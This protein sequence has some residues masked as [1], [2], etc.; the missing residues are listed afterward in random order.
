MTLK[1]GLL[2]VQGA[3]KT[4]TFYGLA[5]K[6]KAEGRIV[7]VVMETAREALARG[8]LANESNEMQE[9]SQLWM[10]GRQMQKEIEAHKTN[11]DFV[12]T[13]RTIY[14]TIAYSEM[15]LSLRQLGKISAIAQAYAHLRPYNILIY[16]PPLSSPPE[17]D[18]VRKAS[19]GFQKSAQRAMES[20]IKRLGLPVIVLES[21]TKFARL[22]EVLSIIYEIETSR[23][24]SIGI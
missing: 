21:K 4:T 1:I 17:I 13:D 15:F 20:M 19:V 2:G 16:F 3:G 11:S 8:L 24:V 22:D 9:A 10:L 14:D 12:I 5:H 6:L 7:N 23:A 18:G